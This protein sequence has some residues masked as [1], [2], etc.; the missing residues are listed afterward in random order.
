MNNIKRI[1]LLPDAEIDDLYERP[2]FNKNEQLL[3][4]KMTQAELD[5]LEQFRNLKTKVYLILQLSYFKA[6]NQFFTFQ[7]EEVIS[8][9]EYVLLT[10]FNKTG[11]SLQGG[12]TRQAI[13]QQ[14]Q[15]ILTLFDYKDCSAENMALIETHLCELLRYYPK[16]H[17]AFRQLL[18][19]LDNQKI[20]IPTYR[21]LQDMFTQAFVKEEYRLSQLIA[22]MPESHQ[23]QLS[24]LIMK[25]DGITQLNIIR[26]DQ[27]NFKY[28]ATHAEVN[29]A[30]ATAELYTFAKE[31]IPTLLLSKNAIRYYADL[32][33]Q[34][35][36]SRLRRLNQSQQWLQALCFVYYRYQQIMD[37]LI[38]SFMY[39]TRYILDEGAVYVEKEMT[40]HSSGVTVDLPRLAKFLKWFPE[41]NPTLSHEALNQAAYKILPQKQFSLLAEFLAGKTFDTKSATRSFVSV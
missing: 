17:D 37:N 12:I 36:A 13:N 15:I 28:V 39:H 41:R 25:E 11:T 10:F 35:P 33:D 24:E 16:V 38:T 14:K 3:Y 7:F 9:V 19:Y 2:I 22:L 27:K 1:Y 5:V 8:D 21:N 34:Y 18:T 26:S 30:L 29:K 32:V 40:K 23:Q 31:F 20:V 6:K 4:F